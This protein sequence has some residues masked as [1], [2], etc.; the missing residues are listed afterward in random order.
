[1]DTMR[2]LTPDQFAIGLTII[3][4]MI[5]TAAIVGGILQTLAN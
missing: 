1:M 3:S 5:V 2:S 4:G